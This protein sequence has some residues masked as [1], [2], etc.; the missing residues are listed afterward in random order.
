MNDIYLEVAKELG[1]SSEIV[2]TVVKHK[3]SWLRKQL[4]EINHVVIL[5]N[6]FGT[7]YLPKNKIK[8][9]LKSL[10]VKNEKDKKTL[11]EIEKYENLLK[12]IETTE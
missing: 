4:T 1:V 5:D 8:K 6:N 11:E 12:R 3:F 10:Y 9:Y 7:F 2:E